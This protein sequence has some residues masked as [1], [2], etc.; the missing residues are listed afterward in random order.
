[1]TGMN[2]NTPLLLLYVD[3]VINALDP[4]YPTASAS[5]HWPSAYRTTQV[6]TW[7]ITYAPDLITALRARHES[8]QVRVEFLTTWEDRARDNLA[9]ALGLPRWPVFGRDPQP[10]EPFS[11]TRTWWKYDCVRNYLHAHPDQPI[12]WLDDHLAYYD[13]VLRWANTLPHMLAIPV[14]P[15]YGLLPSDLARIDAFIDSGR[16]A[17]AEVA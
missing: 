9:P 8:G 2:D 12:I 1:M 15:G 6:L 4:V 5:D 7:T 11:L 3:G 13:S 14:N 16:R 10:D 17:A